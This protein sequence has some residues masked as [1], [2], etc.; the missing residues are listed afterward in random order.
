MDIFLSAQCCLARAGLWYPQPPSSVA[1]AWDAHTARTASAAHL[2]HR[3]FILCCHLL[4]LGQGLSPDFD[5]SHS[6]PGKARNLPVV[7]DRYWCIDYAL[8]ATGV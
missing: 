5:N 2:L 3:I 6:M 8:V 7:A 4:L 1:A